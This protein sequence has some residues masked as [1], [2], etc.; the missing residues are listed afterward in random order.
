MLL[1]ATDLSARYGRIPIL[2]GIQ[3]QVAAGEFVG[4]LGHNGMGKTTLLRT[5]MGFGRP[6]RATRPSTRRCSPSARRPSRRWSPHVPRAGL[7]RLSVADLRMASA[8]RAL[9]TD[10][11]PRDLRLCPPLTRRAAA[12]AAASRLLAIARR[13]A[14]NRRSSSRPTRHQPSIIDVAVVLRVTGRQGDDPPSRTGVHRRWPQPGPADPEG[15]D[16]RELQPADCVTPT[17]RTSSL[18]V[19]TEASRR[20]VGRCASTLTR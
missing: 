20:P 12:P 13:L 2:N 16:L 19:A 5:L 7:P 9:L 17:C 4:V 6:A 18:S 11:D 10:A 15:H 8:G 14:A 3:L 1:R